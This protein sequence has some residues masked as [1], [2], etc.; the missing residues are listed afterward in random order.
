M[1]RGDANAVECI[2]NRYFPI[3]LRVAIR[4][5]GDFHHG[6]D[7][8]HDA[9]LK[10]INRIGTYKP[11]ARRTP[12][13]WFMAVLNNT[14]LDWARRMKLR[15]PEGFARDD[16]GVF[17][18]PADEPSPHDRVEAE[19]KIAAVQAAM[20]M[21]DAEQRQLIMLRVYEELSLEEVREAM[22]LAI[23]L[24]LEPQADDPSSAYTYSQVGGGL[25]RARQRLGEL[26]V[27]KWPDLFP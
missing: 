24:A 9:I 18:P 5:T 27:E 4:L 14:F 21:L 13:A 19:E 12:R 2:Y 16:G 10:V 17:E 15:R 23:S 8:A 11:A 1:K 7:V 26:L 25:Y 6:Q 22:A 20:M 3:F